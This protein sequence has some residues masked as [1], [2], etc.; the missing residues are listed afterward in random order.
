VLHS[1]LFPLVAAIALCTVTCGT[2]SLC[3]YMWCHCLLGWSP[4]LPR[5]LMALLLL[6]GLS[7]RPPLPVTPRSNGYHSTAGGVVGPGDRNHRRTPLQS[8][9]SQTMYAATR[10]D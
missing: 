4:P 8:P 2:S 7:R 10:Y 6:L 1:S 3:R 5:T 9:I